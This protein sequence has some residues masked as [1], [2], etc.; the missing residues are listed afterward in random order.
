MRYDPAELIIG[1][2]E[3]E[4]HQ[5]AGAWDVPA[6]YLKEAMGL[7]DDLLDAGIITEV[8]RPV[9]WCTQG[10]FV[11]KPGATGKLRLVTHYRAPN[12][13]PKRQD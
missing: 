5:K 6:H 10:F 8:K 2:E 13:A 4:P 7:V 9:Y 12:Q 1:K 11:E 3:V